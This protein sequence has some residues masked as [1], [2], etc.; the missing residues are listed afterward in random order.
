MK[1]QQIIAQAAPAT[2]ES[3]VAFIPPD[4]EQMQA[5]TLKMLRELQAELA[6][7]RAERDMLKT[8]ACAVTKRGT[9]KP[10]TVSGPT[11]D[12]SKPGDVLYINLPATVAVNVRTGKPE[13]LYLKQGSRPV[14]FHFQGEEQRKAFEKFFTACIGGTLADRLPALMVEATWYL[15]KKDKNSKSAEELNPLEGL[16]L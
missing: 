8:A 14:R 11:N 1:K 12:L 6:D 4:V 16:A 10:Y 13:A 5:Q 3:P 9:G 2:T 7:V 15:P